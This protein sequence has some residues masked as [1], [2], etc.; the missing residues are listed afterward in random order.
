[1]LFVSML[2]LC[3]DP[4]LFGQSCYAHE[5]HGSPQVCAIKSALKSEL[6]Q[7]HYILLLQSGL[8]NKKAHLLTLL[9]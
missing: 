4:V 5:V 7:I 8:F 9:Y 6:N 2:P 1:M 3:D